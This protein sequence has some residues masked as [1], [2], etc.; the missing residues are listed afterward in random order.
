[1][2][3][4]I[5]ESIDGLTDEQLTEHYAAAFDEYKALAAKPDTEVTDADLDAIERLGAHLDAISTVQ[6]ER[7]QAAAAR[8]EKLAAARERVTAAST[9]EPEPEPDE[10]E[11]ADE[12]PAD[13]AEPEE[14]AEA[15]IEEKEPV[16]AAASSSVEKALANSSPGLTVIVPRVNTA[17][18]A[19]GKSLPSMGV[20]EE[21]EDLTAVALEFAKTAKR[22]PA[23]DMSKFRVPNG[24][25]WGLSEN[26]TRNAFARFQRSGRVHEIGQRM[27]AEE[28][29][30]IVNDAGRAPSG[31][32]KALV[33]A[34]GWCAPSETVYDFCSYET[35]S[36]ILDVPT[37]TINR[38]GLNFTKG[39]DYA[40]IAANAASGFHQTETQAEA[41]TE[42][43]CIAVDCPPFED[44]RL[45][46]V[47]FCLTNGILTDTAY[48][49]LGRRYLE[50][51]AVAHAHKVNK[52]VID[53]ILADIGAAVSWAGAQG[54]AVADSLEGLS[55][56][57][58]K[59]RNRY[60]MGGNATIEGFMPTWAKPIFQADLS[61]RTGVDMLN[62]SDA[63]LNSYLAA[64]DLRIQFVEDYAPIAD[65]ATDW[66][67][68]IP[69]ALYPAGAYIKGTDDVISL[70]SIYDSV[71]ISTNTFTAAFFEEGIL[72]ANRCAGGVQV[73]IPVCTSGQT[74]AADITCAAP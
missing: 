44:H 31:G 1:M 50:I 39:P 12:E 28:Q 16:M 47:G 51:L 18:V 29:L 32:A 15:Q 35:V 25:A 48:P 57:A 3:Y 69:A 10:E 73:S 54:A 8:V 43:V 34:G 74:G 20:N 30:R 33:A 7:A 6:T 40:T 37:I 67:A 17:M 72:V 62:V 56:Y 66:P 61:R 71:N 45:D 41:G 24:G 49:E 53:G 36:G 5:P 38:G 11:E 59:L 2:G 58:W 9:P 21:F 23:G 65:N 63:Q 14:V 70:D 64:R 13:T 22:G 55:F 46:V 27:S 4:E 60:A 52:Y 68:T 19:S 42:K 26:H